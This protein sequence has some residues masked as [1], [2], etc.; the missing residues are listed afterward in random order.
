[1]KQNRKTGNR[2][3]DENHLRAGGK[4]VWPGSPG[5]ITSWRLEIIVFTISRR[6]GKSGRL[7]L[8]A[9]RERHPSRQ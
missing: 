2:R 9:Y 3:T 4:E 6:A 8:P 7:P 1:L 5:W